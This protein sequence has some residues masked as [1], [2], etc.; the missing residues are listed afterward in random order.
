MPAADTLTIQAKLD[1]FRTELVDLAFTLD[2]Q[3]RPDAADVAMT[4]AARVGE[5]CEELVAD[6]R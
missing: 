5:L 3:G 2:R 6:G 4:T 1:A